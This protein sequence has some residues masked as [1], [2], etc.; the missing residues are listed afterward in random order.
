MSTFHPFPRLPLELRLAIWEMTVEPREVE[1]RIVLPT[2]EDPIEA[3]YWNC[4]EHWDRIERARFDEAMTHAPTTKRGYRRAKTKLR[5]ETKPYRPYVH[6]V[7]SMIPPALHTCREARNHLVR[8]DHG[9]YQPISLHADAQPADR[10]Y[11]WLNLDIDLLNIGTSYLL[12]FEPIAPAIKCLKLSRENTLDNLWYNVE[13]RHILPLFIN[14]KKIYVVCS[15]SIVNWS[16]DD[17]YNYC[18]PCAKENLVFIDEI[19]PLG[20]FEAGYLELD[21]YVDKLY[22]FPR[23]GNVLYQPSA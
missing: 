15:D 1:V 16:N 7:S 13:G 21:G 3:K 6:M 19:S 12:Y 2:P 18:W 8:S 11:V 17:V 22:E 10:R 20:Y 14:V 5:Q 23:D 4:P 9:L